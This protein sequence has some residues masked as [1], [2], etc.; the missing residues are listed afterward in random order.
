MYTC[1]H[2]RI[3]GKSILKK[4]WAG[5][6]RWVPPL[7]E[8]AH[9]RTLSHTQTHTHTHVHKPTHTNTHA[10][11][12]THT[13]KHARTRALAHA[14]THAHTHLLVEELRINKIERSEFLKLVLVPLNNAEQER[15]SN[16][17]T[18]LRKSWLLMHNLSALEY[19]N[20]DEKEAAYAHHTSTN[21]NTHA[22]TFFFSHTHAYA[23]THSHI[24][25]HTFAHT[26]KHT[27]THTHTLMRRGSKYETWPGN[28][29]G[30]RVSSIC[31]WWTFRPNRKF[32]SV[33]L[34]CC[35]AP[36]I[37][38]PYTNCRSHVT[39]LH[40]KSWKVDPKPKTV[41]PPP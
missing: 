8:Y 7:D 12:H 31:L 32:E 14:H 37:P 29:L 11:T 28:G 15:S 2:R 36:M 21:T 19:R 40:S 24:H 1:I 16:G 10:L 13:L 18:T 38:K 6:T 41:N 35:I 5:L 34:L 9:A 3:V 4:S 27:S 22:R 33:V 39:C 20:L 23:H 25:T 26:L 17:T 30:V